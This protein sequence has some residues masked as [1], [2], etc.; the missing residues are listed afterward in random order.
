MTLSALSKKI[1]K[2]EN[3]INKHQEIISDS[4]RNFLK[5]GKA[6]FARFTGKGG[7]RHGKRHQPAG[8]CGAL[9]GP[10]AV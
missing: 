2:V 1:E 8:H 3:E 6:F 7:K 4:K 9:A 5:T 10:V